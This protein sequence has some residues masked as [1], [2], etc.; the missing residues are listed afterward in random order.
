MFETVNLLTNDVARLNSAL[1][2]WTEALGEVDYQVLG[3]IEEQWLT[4][5]IP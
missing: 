5:S 1:A 2:A 4:A 3:G